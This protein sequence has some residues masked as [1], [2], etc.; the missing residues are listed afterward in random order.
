MA[1]LVG[2]GRR[3][4]GMTNLLPLRRWLLVL[5]VAAS[6]LPLSAGRAYACSCAYGGP[7][8][9][10]ARND[11][12]FIGSVADIRGAGL[13]RQVWTFAVERWVKGDLGPTVEV[14]SASSGA[15]CGFELARG[16]SRT[17]ASSR[18]A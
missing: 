11:A 7:G 15:S 17:C 16:S 12:A 13:G 18:P 4:T 5:V 6:L 2:T 9:M 3:H 8:E 14:K 10:L 1:E